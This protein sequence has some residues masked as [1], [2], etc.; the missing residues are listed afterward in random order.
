MA[1]GKF[2]DKIEVDPRDS[3]LPDDKVDLKSLAAYKPGLRSQKT[4]IS[5]DK[6]NV[7]P[8]DPRA[9]KY[10]SK[11]I[12]KAKDAK[13]RVADRKAKA[14]EA[15]PEETAKPAETIEAKNKE[16]ASEGPEKKEE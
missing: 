5:D 7:R 4:V 8:V 12:Q 15:K 10:I 2:Y 9:D 1:Q 16:P 11:M 14:A 6:V 3:V 13:Q